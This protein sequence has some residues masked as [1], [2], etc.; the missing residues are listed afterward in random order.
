MFS[1]SCFPDS[2]GKDLIVCDRYRARGCDVNSGSERAFVLVAVVDTSLSPTAALSAIR[3]GS[4]ISSAYVF[5]E[6]PWT[7]RRR[8]DER[9]KIVNA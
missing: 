5:V 1:F 3:Y 9:P 4:R 7:R 2:N 8:W 6:D